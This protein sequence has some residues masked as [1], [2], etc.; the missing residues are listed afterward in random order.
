M[1]S[2]GLGH[3]SS[4]KVLARDQLLVD[5]E[6]AYQALKTVLARQP[7]PEIT[8]Q[9]RRRRG[10]EHLHPGFTALSVLWAVL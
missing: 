8:E 4:A 5:K 6:K 7:G 2:R 1:K 9:A 3:R 10:S